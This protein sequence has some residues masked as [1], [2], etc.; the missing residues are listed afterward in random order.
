MTGTLASLVW[1]DFPDGWKTIG[2]GGDQGSDPHGAP[3]SLGF[4]GNVLWIRWTF[5]NSLLVV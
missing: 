2:S 3:G 1:E 5:L 4:E